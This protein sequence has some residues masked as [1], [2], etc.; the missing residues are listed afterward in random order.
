M[1]RYSY[2]S[3][4]D[5]RDCGVAAL[6]MILKHYGSKYSL[7]YLRE[8]AQ[9]SRE[10]TSALGLIEAAKQLGMKTK[11]IRADMQLFDEEELVYPFIVYVVKNES[12][13]HYY[14]I[15]GQKNGQLII[16][17]PDPSRKM[18]TMKREDFVKEWTA[19][20]L[21]F[22]P[23]EDYT[24]H[25]EK[26]PGLL[27][28]VP[29]LFKKKD[30]IATIVTLSFVVTIINVAGSYYLQAMLDSLIPRAAYSVLSIISMGLCVAYIGQQILSFF[31]DYFLSKLSNY[32]SAEVILPYIKHVLSLPMSFFTSRRT[33][34]ITSRFGDASTIIDALASTI[35][36]LFLDVTIV[37]T[38]ALALFIQNHQLF[39]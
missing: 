4:G 38:L 22:E 29:I 36:S 24:V 7:A 3:Q 2:I 23:N 14:T 21:F 20:A 5:E 34:E 28:F 35:L 9:T 30:L 26:I 17:D 15:F 13:Q 6:A 31:K 27:S 12:L 16:G 11:A 19:V 25:K 8:L 33:G 32:L 37:L 1:T 39:G 18:V 10:G